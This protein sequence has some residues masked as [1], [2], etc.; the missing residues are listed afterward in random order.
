[1]K[2]LK[3]YITLVVLIGY[4]L[5]SN[6]QSI[7]I[8]Q[9]V[10]A[11]GLWCFPI[12]KKENSYRY[13]PQR[14]RL[15]L[16]NDSIPEFSF[17]RYITEKPS[18]NNSKTIT[19]AGGGGILNFLVLYDTP[20]ELISNAERF[21]KK[22]FENDEIIIEGPIIFDSGKYTLVSSILNPAGESKK[23][24]LGSG[25]APIIENSKIPLSF[26]VDP[27][28][29]KL[30]L[31]SLKMSTPDVSLIFELGFSGL[32]ENYEAELEIDWSE[33]KKS[34]AFD[35]GGSIYFVGADVGLG[36]DKLRKDNA[37][38]FTSVGK[39]ESME[40]LVQTVY[41]KLLELMFKPTPLE[42]VPEEHRGGLEDAI[43]SLI[44]SN[45]AMGS[46]NTTGF[47]LNVGYQYKEHRTTGKSNMVFKGR[48]LV[49]RNH[50]ITFN[51]GNLYKKYGDNKDIFKDVPLWDPAF[52]QRDVYVGIDGTI[53]NEF[54]KMLNSVTVK[55][56]KKHQSGDATLKEVLLTKNT[57]KESNGK[58]AMS[59]LNHGDADQNE[60]L[61]YE[62]QT[63]WKFIGGGTYSED[64][65]TA[66]ASM[67]NLYTPFQR[68][69][70]EISGDVETLKEKNVR[71][72]A[73]K[74]NYDFFGEPKSKNL[75]IYP[76]KELNDKFFEIT[77][78]KGSD[79]VEYTITWYVKNAAP[80]QKNGIDE[81]GLL[82]IDE[83]PE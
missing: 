3:H 72:V 56:N 8:D 28:K 73:V 76:K 62:Y 9:G 21:L 7:L 75:T 63:V 26:N 81:Y 53:E 15:S 74:I 59:Y 35:A 17:L 39:D 19:E 43:G 69:K 54:D 1:M 27:L 58:I 29:S 52:Q 57:Y 4:C 80:I 50:Y 5:I 37:I 66:T 24:I 40:S 14:A 68:R 46:R 38:K 47:G 44:G 12:H 10:N 51:A 6:G 61:N 78:P 25:S 77:L 23:S 64:W 2:N 13:L 79:K 41:T 55:L 18:E 45:G 31:E 30:L 36:F 48:S 22:K 83:F 60:W 71:A 67:I 82:F 70:I 33:V 42:Q 49:N 34:H 20:Q 65:K 11:D 32:T 16:Q